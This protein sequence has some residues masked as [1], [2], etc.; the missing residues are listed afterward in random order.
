MALIQKAFSDIITFS[1][2]SNATRIGPTGLVEYAPHN[3]L[4]R[5]QEFDNASWTKTNATITANAI[6]APDGTIT[7]DKLVEA[8]TTSVHS[9]TQS[10]TLA[11]GLV[12]TYSVYAKAGERS[13]LIIQPTGDSRF[14]YFN[15]S[16]GA[17]ATIS[18][19]PL[20]TSIQ[21]VGN[22]WYRCS[23]S[24]TSPGA[25]AANCIL[26]SAATDG[27]ASY[28]G[29]GTSGIYL[30]GAQLSVGPYALD[31][32]PTTSAAVYGPRFD[33]DGSGVTIV[34]PVSTNLFTYSEQFDNAAWTKFEVTATANAVAAPDGTITSD[35]ISE[36][37]AN[38]QHAVYASF[39]TTS[40]TTYT[41]SFYAKAGQR[42]KISLFLGFGL[43][44]DRFAWFNLATGTVG[45]V[46]GSAITASITSVGN[47][48]YR[49]A[50]TATAT[51]TGSA[52]F[53]VALQVTGTAGAESYTGTSGSGAYLWGAQ[54]EVGSTATAY[55]VSGATNGF[56]AVPVVSGSAT[57]K[58]LLIEE[59]RT[60]LLTYSEQFNNAAWTPSQASTTANA[61]AS[62]DGT[63][64]ADK[65]VEN[66]ANDY[67]LTA[68][69]SVSV[70]A[71][72]AYTLTVFAKAGERQWV[73]LLLSD[74]SGGGSG[75]SW[76]N[77]GAGV[78]GSS[79]GLTSSSITA[80]SN[81]WYRIAIT[82]STG[83]GVSAEYVQ[84]M[85]GTADG[86]NASA[87]AYAGDGTSGLFLWGAQLEAGS[88][89]TSYI[90]TVASTVT[91]S[92]DVASVNTLSPWFNATE[93][94]IYTE[95]E[96]KGL[97]TAGGGG[98]VIN[99]GAASFA[100]MIV[101]G[102]FNASN[103]YGARV[104]V[105][106]S[107]QFDNFISDPPINSVQKFA[108]GYK[109]NDFAFT[110]NNTSPTVDTSGTIPTGATTMRIGRSWNNNYISGWIR[111][112]SYYPRKL[113]SAEIQALTA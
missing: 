7:A 15:L 91:R 8:A 45:G 31:Y 47:G 93:M 56:R 79:S 27:N 42:S 100:D 103:S 61:V 95:F 97:G 14:A 21:S 99:D 32:T 107:S 73:R 26:Y 9:A 57:P 59:Q 1:R 96:L 34:E 46:Q 52:V 71:S 81:G 10:V 6:A 102:E 65:L 11:A 98:V 105:S 48:W 50:V 109:A 67:H 75:Y 101:L 22:G 86:A 70:S 92:A 74:L 68:V 37:T 30:W 29:D 24:V 51:A 112:I 89:A 106:S 69:S 76:F 64:T 19:S 111:R 43:F 40:G 58:G 87:G 4:L 72:T 49:C 16:T 83:A 41:M 5:S 38:D 35:F 62:P 88:F 82:R 66:S 84:I 44:T 108:A 36:T 3:L 25:V 53:G 85:L 12:Y 110:R 94:S 54:L 33:Y 78:V 63:V 39:S 18:G 28:T 80:L 60:N 104:F 77:L 55:M 2:S 113:S 20:S 13:F 17:V 90:P 23:I